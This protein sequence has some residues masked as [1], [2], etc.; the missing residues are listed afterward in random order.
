MKL[1]TSPKSNIC[2]YC[3]K[4]T[5]KVLESRNA[6]ALSRRRRY[7]CQVCSKRSSTYEVSESFFDEAIE[8]RRLIAGIRKIVFS[9]NELKEQKFACCDTCQFNEGSYCDKEIPVLIVTKRFPNTTQMNLMIATIFREF[10]VN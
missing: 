5:L 6:T 9:D 4:G 1:L 3:H 2:S 10:K 7:E 8:N